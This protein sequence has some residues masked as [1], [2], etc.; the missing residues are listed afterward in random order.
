M[1]TK[2]QK[3][4]IK[5]KL[6]VAVLIA[7][8]EPATESKSSRAYKQPLRSCPSNKIKDLLDLGSNGDIYFLPKQKD[9]P[10]P[11]LTRQAPKSW[12][13]SN[14]SFQTNG[15]GKLILKFF[16]Y[17]ANWEYTIQADIV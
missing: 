3:E 15:R 12:C 1:K 7:I 14:G 8:T 16:E 6:G 9:R 4:N 13:T 10:F 5:D 11:N 17:F 2:N